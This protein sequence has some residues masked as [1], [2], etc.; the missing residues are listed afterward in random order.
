VTSARDEEISEDV[1]AKI[2]KI[3]R[4]AKPKDYENQDE[5]VST[6]TALQVSYLLVIKR[7]GYPIEPVLADI[8]A[9]YDSLDCDALIKAIGFVSEEA[10]PSETEKGSSAS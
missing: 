7:F 2:R 8:R 6:V 4:A 1:L 3:L 5:V 9:N 10:V